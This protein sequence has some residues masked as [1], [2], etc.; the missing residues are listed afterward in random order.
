VIQVFSDAITC[1]WVS[2][3]GCFKW[4]QCLHLWSS[5]WPWRWAPWTTHPATQHYVTEDL[6]SQQ[7]CCKNLKFQI[8]MWHTWPNIDLEKWKSFIFTTEHKEKLKNKTL[9]ENNTNISPQ[10][11]KIYVPNYKILLHY[12]KFKYKPSEQNDTHRM[13]IFVLCSCFF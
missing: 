1:C 8:W 4:S 13:N 10:Q 6:N 5:A 11:N 2:G 3:S 9:N 12:P 7:H